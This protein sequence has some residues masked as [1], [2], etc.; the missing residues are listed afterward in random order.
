MKRKLKYDWADD[1]KGNLVNIAA[2]V[3]DKVYYHIVTHA[4]MKVKAVNS[5]YR[6]THFFL[7][8]TEP[9]NEN[10]NNESY[11]HE[12][13]KRLIKE[14]FYSDTPLVAKYVVYP[15]CSITNSCKIKEKL[16]ELKCG[17]L[18]Y[19]ELILNKEYDT[20]EEERYYEGFI[21]DLKLSDSRCTEKPPVFIEICYKNPCTDNKKESGIRIIEIKINDEQ[22]VPDILEECF[23]QND[24]C[25]KF[26]EENNPYCLNHIPFVCFY[27]FDR[28]QYPRMGRF[29]V[30]KD[31]RGRLETKYDV[32]NV[33][34]KTNVIVPNE[35]SLIEI[36]MVDDLV[37]NCYDNWI[38]EAM[39]AVAAKRGLDV[40]DCR[41][42]YHEIVT[43]I[44]V[45]TPCKLRQKQPYCLAENCSNYQ[46]LP[47]HIDN[48]CE[49]I[50]R[51]PSCRIWP[52][53]NR[54]SSFRK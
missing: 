49:K 32:M 14:R 39:Y 44:R 36:T 4:P 6:R 19:H 8:N 30:V 3:S 7:L 52:Q 10:G 48:L 41:L 5:K 42:C 47:K 12:L 11:Y 20:C 33:T 34:C 18:Y 26:K 9:N 54:I 23:P 28:R 38:E 43:K 31:D 45:G 13:G 2:A 16:P 15:Q 17:D 25:L 51:W 37:R 50:S 24:I 29:S 46:P 21:G 27:G 22:M 40:K 53:I 35:N 1:E